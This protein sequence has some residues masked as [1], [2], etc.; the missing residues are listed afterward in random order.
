IP[1]QTRKSTRL[2]FENFNDPFITHGIDVI[3]DSSSSSSP[4]VFIVAVNHIPGSPSSTEK[5]PLASRIDVFSHTLGTSTAR[6]LHTITHPL[7]RTPNDVYA[8]SENEVYVTNDRWYAEGLMRT[9]ET[10]WP[11]AR[12]SDVVHA[13]RVPA[14][15]AGKNDRQGEEQFVVEAS[16]A[17]DKLQNPNGIGHG[18]TADEIMVASAV[19]GRVWLGSFSAS[20]STTSSSSS[21]ASSNQKHTPTTIQING[22]IEVP[23][24]IDNPSWYQDPYP[25]SS[26]SSDDASGFILAGLKRAVN[27]G[28]TAADPH[29]REGVMVWYVKPGPHPHT[30]ASQWES[31]L[32]WEDDGGLIRNA[33]TAVLVGIDPAKETAAGGGK[34]AWLFVTG[35]SSENAVAVKVDL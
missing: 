32:L 11:G 25:S 10:M 23:S 35:F 3:P 22:T 4:A 16:I 5:C 27:L 24:T 14:A 8:V 20:S 19:G 31:R 34:R 21:S 7:I 26:S 1:S 15:A 6:F 17:V 28:S 9:V 2:A 12:W 33:A 13:T 29:G 18:R 30:P